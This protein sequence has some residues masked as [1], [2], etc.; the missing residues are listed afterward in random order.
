MY[1]SWS[2]VSTSSSTSLQ[3]LVSEMT[4]NMVM[5]TLNPSH[6]L[7]S[8]Y[9]RLLYKFTETSEVEQYVLRR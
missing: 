9:S 4:Y 6:S 8:G 5:G 1:C 3:S 2:V 7:I